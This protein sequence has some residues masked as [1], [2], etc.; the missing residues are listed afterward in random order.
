MVVKNLKLTIFIL[1]DLLVAFVA[2]CNGYGD[3]R[4]DFGWGGVK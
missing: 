3:D 2:F 4:A 1:T